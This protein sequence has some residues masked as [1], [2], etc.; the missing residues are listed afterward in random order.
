MPKN[1]IGETIKKLREQRGMTQEKLAGPHMCRTHIYKIE[2]GKVKPTKE[3][4]T[5]LVN[6]FGYSLEQFFELFFDEKEAKFQATLETIES[7]LKQKNLEEADTLL[8]QLEEDEDFMGKIT[9]RQRTMS[10]KASLVIY[11]GGEASKARKILMEAIKIHIPKFNEKDISEYWLTKDD[12]GIIV[13]LAASYGEEGQL[14]EAANLLYNLKSNF[15]NQYRDSNLKGREYPSIIFNLTRYLT[16]AKRYEEVIELCDIGIKF[17]KNNSHMRLLPLIVLNK[18]R[19]LYEIGDKETCKKLLRQAY[20][21]LE[22]H[23]R[24][25]Y[26]EYIKSYVR[27]RPDIAF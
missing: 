13:K 12:V 7:H 5:T 22:M 23:E 25:E 24:F 9:Y 16:A 27:E 15:D 20:Y 1:H 19:S 18:A 3:T 4:L 2:K 11:K 14:D 10:Y 8:S 17:C 21:T 26:V 6:R